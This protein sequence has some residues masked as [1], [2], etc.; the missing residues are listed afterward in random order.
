MARNSQ[1]AAEFYE[2]KARQC[3]RLTRACID[4]GAIKALK[5]L[6][7][8]YTAIAAALR[9]AACRGNHGDA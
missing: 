5:K 7:Q 1:S 4:P 9:S 6:A 3:L 8:E 2:E